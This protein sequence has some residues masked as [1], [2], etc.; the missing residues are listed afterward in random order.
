MNCLDCLDRTNSVQ[1]FIAL[2]VSLSED[3]L[4]MPVLF[5]G[6]DRQEGISLSDTSLS[7]QF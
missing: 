4:W 6:E 3:L 7:C 1:F 5:H 2:E